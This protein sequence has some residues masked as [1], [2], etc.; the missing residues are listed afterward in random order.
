M[1]NL[2]LLFLFLISAIANA[3]SNDGYIYVAPAMEEYLTGDSNTGDDSNDGSI[4]KPYATWQKAI[5][6][7]QP[8]DTVFFRGGRYHSLEPSVIDPDAYGGPRGCSGTKENPIVY[9]SYPGE[10]AILDCSRHCETMEYSRFGKTYNSAISISKATHLHFKDFEV[11]N[12]FQCDSTIDGAITATLSCNLTFEHIIMHDVGQRGFYITGGCWNESDD[13]ENA[14]KWGYSCPDTTRFINCDVYNLCDSLVSNMGNAAD[15]YKMGHYNGNYLEWI[16]CRVWNYT[17]DAWDPSSLSG[18]KRVFRNCWAMAGDK[19]KEADNGDVERNGFKCSGPGSDW[20][21]DYSSSKHYLEMYNC[22]A[23]NCNYGFYEL[24]H[25]GY[26]RNNALLYNNIA[27]RNNV[28]FASFPTDRVGARTSVYKNNISYGSTSNDATGKPYDIYLF[29]DN[30]E[31]SNCT[32]VYSSNYPY[33]VKNPD[34]TIADSDFNSVDHETIVAQLTAPRKKDGSLPD[35]IALMPA[36]GSV[37]IDAGVNVGMHYEG[38]APEVS[39]FEFIPGLVKIIDCDPNPVID[40]VNV[41]YYSAETTEIN[42]EILDEEGN[43]KL[44]SLT[45]NAIAGDDN[46][47]K[48]NFQS[49]D[50]GFYTIK[51]SNISSSHTDTYI[52]KKQSVQS[53]LDPFKLVEHSYSTYDIFHATYYNPENKSVDIEIK[54]NNNE[55]V[56]GQT[57]KGIK[58]T[59]DINIDL[60]KLSKGEYKVIFKHENGEENCKT[61]KMSRE[62]E[63]EILSSFPNPTVDLFVVKFFSPDAGNIIISLTDESDSEVLTMDYTAKEGINKAVINLSDLPEG[64]YQMNFDNASTILSTEVT[65]QKFEF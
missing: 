41:R 62:G 57:D 9:M 51:L 64:N 2:L 59:N 26:E 55:V 27:F 61:I 18:A 43:E 4:D 36:P 52:I 35:L 31:L 30:Y 65:K 32:W 60:S 10:W 37:L 49:Y 56:I 47:L 44:T 11:M 22:I 1:K 38:S 50:D 28:G 15:G 5:D 14:P 45:D 29:G 24:D 54:D 33:Q 7:A 19:Y 53:A 40:D 48:I 16:G 13:P 12:I 20:S 17:D 58:G 63:F 46:Y 34:I 3:Q 8:G 42:I 6:M 21:P 25:I 23:Y 39:A